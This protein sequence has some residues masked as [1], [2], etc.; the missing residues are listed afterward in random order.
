MRSRVIF[1]SDGKRECF[2]NG[3][4]VTEVEFD[5]LVPNKLINYE[6]G[7]LPG[8][9]MDFGDWSSENGGMGRYCPQKASAPKASDGYCRSRNELI[10]WAK[11]KDK[12]IEKD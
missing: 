10:N 11:S 9:Y 2:V 7:E 1:R 5:E 3:N 8:M 6:A 4:Q 12:C